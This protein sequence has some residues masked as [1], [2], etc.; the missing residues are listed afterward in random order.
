MAAKLSI[1]DEVRVLTRRHTPG[2][3]EGYAGKITRVGRIY[4]AADYE[5]TRTD[6]RGEEVT[7]RHAVEFDMATGVERGASH[8]YGIVVRTL[9]QAALARRRRAAEEI[10]RAASVSLMSRRKFTLEQIEALA[11]VAATFTTDPDAED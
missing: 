6:W 2:P 7:S 11:E 10:L 3:E 5:T 1:G 8:H 4:A 9:E